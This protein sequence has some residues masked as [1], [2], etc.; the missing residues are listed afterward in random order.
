MLEKLLRS[1]AG[2]KTLGVVLF[3]DGL[4]LRE[5]ARRAGIS[6]PEAKRELDLLV[7]LGALESRL[8]GR[9]VFFSKNPACPFLPD[10]KNLYL[11]TEGVIPQL[12]GALV[13][14]FGVK[15]AFVFGSMASGKDRP[16]SDIDL[17][18]IGEMDDGELSR[19][20]FGIQKQTGR[21]INFIPWTGKEL[22]K[23]SKA[24]SAFFSNLLK[25]K[26]LWLA[27]DE[28]EFVRIAQEVTGAK[29]RH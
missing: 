3:E 24:R 25:G 7:S 17:M 13:G 12:K 16:Q 23:N 10:L 8:A 22:A 11:K 19:R 21:E 18:V 14:L 27:G 15:F 28:N 5:I 29:S 1:G 6:P 2:V 26:R 4:H 20:L 9:Q